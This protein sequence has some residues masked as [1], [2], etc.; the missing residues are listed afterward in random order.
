MDVEEREAADDVKLNLAVFVQKRLA[1]DFDVQT[2]FR[3][4]PDSTTQTPSRLRLSHVLPLVNYSETDEN[5]D[6]WCA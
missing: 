2:L 3:C 5:I 4:R 6:L 1:A